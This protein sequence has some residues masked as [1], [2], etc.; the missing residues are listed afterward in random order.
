MI[1]GDVETDT[2]IAYMFLLIMFGAVMVF[3]SRTIFPVIIKWIVNRQFK[4]KCGG[5]NDI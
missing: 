1:T 3:L 4:N 2:A 5:N